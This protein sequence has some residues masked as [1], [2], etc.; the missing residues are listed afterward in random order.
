MSSNVY[1]RK[2]LE[3]LTPQETVRSP[4][5][6]VFLVELHAQQ[7]CVETLEGPVTNPRYFVSYF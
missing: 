5:D 3:E 6:E 4:T 7:A 1:E 2:S